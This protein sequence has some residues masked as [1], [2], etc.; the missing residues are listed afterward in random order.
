[1]LA[2]D[3][4]SDGTVSRPEVRSNSQWRRRSTSSSE[5]CQKTSIYIFLSPL[6]L[7]FGT[8]PGMQICYLADSFHWSRFPPYM[9]VERGRDHTL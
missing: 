9:C 7:N 3:D 2:T 6:L 5:S 8:G 4:G 1:M